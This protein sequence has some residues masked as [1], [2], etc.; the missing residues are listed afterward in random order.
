MSYTVYLYG[1]CST[2]QK[3]LRFLEKRQLSYKVKDISQHPP[4][5]RELEEMLELQKGDIKKLFNTSGMLYRELQLSQKLDKMSINE[6]LKLLS[7]HGMLVKRPFI[8]GKNIGLIG[9]KEDQWQ[10][11]FL[12]TRELK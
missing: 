9:F 12:P 5:M 2:C 7:N 3:A 10:N 1:K 8:L 4:S 11:A 6:A